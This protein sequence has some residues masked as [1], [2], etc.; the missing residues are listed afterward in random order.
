MSEAIIMTTIV[1]FGLS[2]PLTVKALKGN[3]TCAVHDLVLK[4]FD[5]SHTSVCDE[6]KELRKELRESITGIYNKID[7]IQKR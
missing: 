2:I 4:N 3:D 6:I 5:N 7:D 1:T